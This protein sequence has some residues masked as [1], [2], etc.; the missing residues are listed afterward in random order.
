VRLEGLGK[1]KNFI[2]V[3]G[4]RTCVIPVVVRDAYSLL[5]QIFHWL[6]QNI[7]LLHVTEFLIK[8]KTNS[9]A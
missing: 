3:V 5:M 2:H 6:I 7:F 9:V 8:Q 1:L 4:P